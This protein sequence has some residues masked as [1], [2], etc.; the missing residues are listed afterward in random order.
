MDWR[1]QL[2]QVTKIDAD[3]GDL[4]ARNPDLSELTHQ[5]TMSKPP[6][7]KGGEKGGRRGI[8]GEKRG[9]EKSGGDRRREEG[10]KRG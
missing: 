8:G 7:V 6:E 3:Y 5:R 2:A 4:K 10:K 9:W 1:S